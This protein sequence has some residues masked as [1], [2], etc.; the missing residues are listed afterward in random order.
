MSLRWSGID[1]S[2]YQTRIDWERLSA[3]FAILRAGYG[4]VASQKDKLFETHY[5]NAKKEKVNVSAYGYSYAMSEAEARQEAKAC[6]ECLKGKQ[7]EYPIYYDV[8]EKK[9]YALGKKTV[10]AIVRA[11][12]E[13]LEAAGYWVGLYTN[14]SWYNSVIED[15]IKSRYAIWIAHWDVS[16]PGISGQYGVWQYGVG[17]VDGVVGDCDKDYS[18]LDYPTMIKAAG[19]NGFAPTPTPTP[20]KKT[21]DV[22]MT[23]DN[24][25]Y[26]GTLT[27][28]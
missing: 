15:D 27:E 13:E 19:K 7:F 16:K 2:V 24:V 26:S 10:S 1:V 6:I 21:I 4:K 8:E 11:F 25:T 22:T 12:C 17:A 28:K 9:Q 3:N 18:Y 5:A 20:G 23:V 14:A